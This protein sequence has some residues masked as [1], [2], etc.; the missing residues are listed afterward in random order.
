MRILVIICLFNTLIFANEIKSITYNGLVRMSNLIAN[1]IASIKVG[2]KL[3][4]EAINQA[5]I[6]F[7]KQDYFDDIYAEFDE[8]NGNLS[9]HFKEKPT[10]NNIEIKGYGSDTETNDIKKLINIKRGDT[11]DIYKEQYAKSVI[12]QALEDKGIYGSVIE[13]DNIKIEDSISLIFNV[14]KGENIIIRKSYYEGATLPKEELES[15]SANK[16]RHSWLGW[17]P[18]WS[19][20]ELKLKELEFDNLRIQDVY[21]RQG[22]LDAVISNP[23]VS[24][25]FLNYDAVLMYKIIEGK[26]YK[27]NGIRIKKIGDVDDVFPIETLESL[28]SI[29]VGEY[30]N[31]ESVRRDIEVIKSHIMDKGYAYTRI[32]PDLD[33]DEE[34]SEVGVIFNIEVGNKVHINDVIITGNTVSG[35]RVIRREM[36]IAPG[37]TYSITQ[38]RKSENA[39]RRTGFFDKVQISEI[40]VDEDSMNLLVEVAEGRTGEVMFGLG[41]GSYDKLMVNASLKERNLFGTG[42]S[43]QFYVNYS[44]YTQLFNLGFTNPR[45]LDSEYSSSINVYKSFF[46][47]YD[48]V[49]DSIG[50]NISAGKNL[51]DSLAVNAVYEISK[52]KLSDFRDVGQGGGIYASY[53]P[54]HGIL[55]SS[56]TPGLYFDNTDD[57]YF[58]K[59]GAIIESSAEFAGIGGDAKYIK[60]FGKAGFY[61]HLKNLI[62]FDLILRYKAQIG[63]IIGEIGN[64]TTKGVP[65]TDTFYMGGIGTVRGYETYSLTPRDANGLRIGGRYIFANSIEAS[66]GFLEAVNMRIS[67]FF[68]YGMIGKDRFDE[69]SRMSWGL[70]LEWVSPIGPLVFVFPFA[71]NP[72]ENDDTSSFEFTMGTRF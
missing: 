42:M 72:K 37:D 45:I 65:I 68:D 31:I 11:Y 49:E 59:N 41:Y 9:F 66:Y 30:F 23:L 26:R 5:I 10:I 54:I 34:N 1:E 21:M 16:E 55:T 69:I 29:K 53:F 22:Y 39:L 17:L 33:K 7:Y 8:T 18:W 44:K 36:L 25:N 4:K 61:Y 63:G 62:D 12:I 46:R 15:L 6:A 71:I 2:D 13:I 19:S 28:S 48:Y 57:Y 56:I 70:A 64:K 35:D 32:T 3:D 58:P 20:G 24:A 27:V 67:A 40:R 47:N 43:A 52:T 14:N 50:F 38:I 51:T 60:L